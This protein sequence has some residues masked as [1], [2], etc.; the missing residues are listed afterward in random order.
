M[1]QKEE[2][3][4]GRGGNKEGSLEDEFQKR[5]QKLRAS[6]CRLNKYFIGRRKYEDLHKEMA[7]RRSWTEILGNH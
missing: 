1:D 4:N 5:Q 7:N 6:L 2:M 3:K